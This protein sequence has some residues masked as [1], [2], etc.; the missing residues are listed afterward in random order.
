MPYIHSFQETFISRIKVYNSWQNASKTLQSK[1]D[2]EAK[3]QST[4]KTEKLPIVQQEI[5][6][7]SMLLNIVAA[8]YHYAN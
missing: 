2:S 6:D 4:G 3:M 1:R 5:K 8:L 7:V